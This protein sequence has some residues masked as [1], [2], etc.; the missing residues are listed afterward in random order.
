MKIPE[1]IID[2]IERLQTS[3][4]QAYIVGGA[5]RDYSLR[6]QV[7]DWD[8][9]TSA[10]GVEIKSI[11]RDVKH[12]SLKHETI[13][14]VQGAQL[15]EVT[16][17]RGAGGVGQRIEE[18]LGHRDFTMNAMA[19]DKDRGIVLDPYGGRR[20][21]SRRLVRAVRDP[22]DRFLEDPVRLIRAIR[23]A[24]ELGFRVET[25][26]METIAMMA[27]ELNT[28]APERI[29]EE[30]MK[31]LMSQKPS[32]GLNSMFRTGLL[33][34]IIPELLEGYRK[35]Q[36]ASHRYTIYKHIMETID[37][38]EA[39]P[40]LRLTALLHDIAKPRVRKKSEGE[41]HFLGHEQ[42]SA[43][44]GKEIMERLKFSQEMI[45]EV[46]NLISH[47]MDMVGSLEGWSDG[48][49]RRLIRHVGSENIERLLCFREADILAHGISDEKMELFLEI[50]GRIETLKRG[51]LVLQNRDLAVDGNDVMEIL[52]LSEGPEVGE[53]LETLILKVT[54]HPELNTRRTLIDLLGEMR[55]R[56]AEMHSSCEG[57]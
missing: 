42:E 35:K 41:Y 32:L 36:D 28:V 52:G 44:L 18:D 26:T 56:R 55:D 39:V 47:H 53:V 14:L 40:A 31:I 37:L 54:D 7:T 13:T 3:G 19:Y 1:F 46:T 57:G 43:T 48:A 50:K 30:F 9:A 2:V 17:F 34:Q 16:T 10:T 6:R 29:R 4:H 20:D 15:Y 49:L 8:V 12:F 33:K 11:F 21:L 51:P 27:E 25:R 23:F 38:A 24:T 5:V 45:S 22:K